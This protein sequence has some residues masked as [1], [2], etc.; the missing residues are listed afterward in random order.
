MSS[1]V[2]SNGIRGIAVDWINDNV[3][4]T[5]SFPHETFLEV[6]RTD[7]QHRMV[8][9]KT[10][11]DSPKEIAVN[12]VKR[13]ARQGRGCGRWRGQIRRKVTS[14]LFHHCVGRM[15]LLSSG[16]IE[17]LRCYVCKGLVN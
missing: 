16:I 4:F 17:V 10:I 5:N 6:C 2:G 13:Y 7:G 9:F 15:M 12:P 11:K 14:W 1:G 8:L 3:Y